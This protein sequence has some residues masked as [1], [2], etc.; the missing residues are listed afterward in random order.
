MPTA[1]ARQPENIE[2]FIVGQQWEICG[3][4]QRRTDRLLPSE[5]ACSM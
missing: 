4:S 3:L 1:V 2:G 5:C